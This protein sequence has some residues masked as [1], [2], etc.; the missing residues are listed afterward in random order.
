M[1]IILRIIKIA[2]KNRFH[3][4]AAYATMIVSAAAYLFLPEVF[5]NTIDSIAE[6][7]D[8][9]VPLSTIEILTLSG[10]ILGL[11]SIRGIFGFGQQYYSESVSQLAVYEIRNQLF[12]RIQRLSLSFHDKSHTGN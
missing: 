5:G 1:N 6:S 3:I 12:D 2:F 7:L 11:S 4:T 8:G 9:G 10:I